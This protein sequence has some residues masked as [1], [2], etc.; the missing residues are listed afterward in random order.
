MIPEMI[1]VRR[2]E[3]VPSI[4]LLVGRVGRAH[5]LAGDVAVDVRTDEPDHRFAAGTT[6][7]STRGTLTVESTK[8]HSGR[9]LVRF[10]EICDRTTAES[11]RG[12]ELRVEVAEDERPDDPDEFY[13]HQLVGLRAETDVGAVLGEVTDVLH[14]PAHDM[15]VVK[16]EGRDVL[17]PFVTEFVPVVDLESARMVIVDGPGLFRDEEEGG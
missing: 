17:I 4:E 5:G 13:D 3:T 2:E 16:H 8:W 7:T 12:T 15:V 6:F 11:L 1:V 14:L 9:L 10:E